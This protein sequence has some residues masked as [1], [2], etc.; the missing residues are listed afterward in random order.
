MT[1]EADSAPQKLRKLAT[2]T[3]AVVVPVHN[4]IDPIHRDRINCAKNTILLTIAISVPK[5]RSSVPSFAF[6]SAVTSNF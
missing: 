3:T 4:T 6:P 1:C 5:P 2:L